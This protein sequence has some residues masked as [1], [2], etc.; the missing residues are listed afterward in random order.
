MFIFTTILSFITRQAIALW[1]FKLKLLSFVLEHWKAS[2]VAVAILLSLLH[3]NGLKRAI[4]SANSAK[5]TAQKA[6]IAHVE[7][8]KEAAIERAAL[9][10]RNQML[11]QKKTESD[12]LA[13]EQI[14][15]QSNLD[16]EQLKKAL[17]HE[18]AN[19]KRII[20]TANMLR[21]NQA[22]IDAG[23]P[24]VP[25]ATDLLANGSDYNA[26][27]SLNQLCE[28]TTKDYNELMRKW[29]DHCKIYRCVNLNESSK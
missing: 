19:I 20:A 1:E 3:Y 4:A 13:Y 27:V 21:D 16:R 26:V 2:L 7:A 24:T 8:D 6:L 22:S 15:N 10:K 18:K 9:N 29:L 12:K 14:L 17:N 28:I 25:I 23:L 11:A 5:I